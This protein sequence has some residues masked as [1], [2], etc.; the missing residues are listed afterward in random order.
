M[1]RCYQVLQRKL[2]LHNWSYSFHPLHR[3]HLR[4]L[5][6]T[7]HH[8]RLVLRSTFMSH[9]RKLE[10][11]ATINYSISR[12]RILK[13]YCCHKVD[14]VCAYYHLPF[15][16]DLMCNTSVSTLS[17]SADR[18][19]DWQKPTNSLRKRPEATILILRTR[20]VKWSTSRSH[21]RHC[22]T[23]QLTTTLMTALLFLL[24]GPVHRPA[25]TPKISTTTPT[26]RANILLPCQPTILR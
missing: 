10:G 18:S 21:N 14:K 19:S 24:V 4:W 23:C 20:R 16:L 2:C 25:R 15:L 26:T 13:E 3:H 5:P 6:F 8:R 11:M 1:V 9:P 17:S 22:P 7:P 12:S